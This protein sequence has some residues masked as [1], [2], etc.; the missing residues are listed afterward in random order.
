MKVEVGLEKFRIVADDGTAASD[1]ALF[2]SA[3]ILDHGGKRYMCFMLEDDLDKG[4]EPVVEEIV[5]VA[6]VVTL[7]EEVAFEDE[8]E[9]EEEGDEGEDDEGKDDPRFEETVGDIQG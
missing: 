8:S 2:G 4:Q 3:A 1:A 5:F 9:D 6:T 7:Y